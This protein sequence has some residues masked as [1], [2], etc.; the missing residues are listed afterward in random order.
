[1]SRKGLHF[2]FICAAYNQI[3]VVSFQ[4]SSTDRLSEYTLQDEIPDP[5]VNFNL[6][7]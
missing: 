5:P 2:V 6:R 1:M 4:I 7:N 3:A